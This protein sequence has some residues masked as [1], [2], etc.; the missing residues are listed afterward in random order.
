MNTQ[1]LL[2]GRQTPDWINQKKHTIAHHHNQNAE[3]H[4]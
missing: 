4:S 2:D 1:M 3:K